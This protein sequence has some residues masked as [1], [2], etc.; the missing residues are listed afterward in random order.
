MPSE[1]DV[2]RLLKVECCPTAPRQALPG[3]WQPPEAQ[4]VAVQQRPDSV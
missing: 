1:A 3:S 2:G 4:Q